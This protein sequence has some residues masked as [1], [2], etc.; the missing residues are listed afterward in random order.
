MTPKV[1]VS[2]KQVGAN[3]VRPHFESMRILRYDKF[4]KRSEFKW[5]PKI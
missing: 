5:K 4:M 1:F 3:S 2:K